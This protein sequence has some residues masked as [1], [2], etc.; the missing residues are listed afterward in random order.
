MWQESNNISKFGW[1]FRWQKFNKVLV[2]HLNICWNWR[3]L[4]KFHR[5]VKSMSGA[6]Y[7]KVEKCSKVELSYIYPLGR[8]SLIS[9]V[10]TSENRSASKNGPWTELWWRS[11][12]FAV[13][14]YYFWQ[15]FLSNDFVGKVFF[16]TH[17]PLTTYFYSFH[18]QMSQFHQKLGDDSLLS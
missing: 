6:L 12:I 15:C 4:D 13:P 1:I 10:E 16:I 9:C 14:L 7:Y 8:V 17:L 11:H 18:F 2:S 5:R 3:Q